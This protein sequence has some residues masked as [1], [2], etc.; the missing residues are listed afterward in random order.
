[1]NVP[2]PWRDPWFLGWI[3]IEVLLLGGLLVAFVL[4]SL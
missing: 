3:A 4:H 2:E 1:M